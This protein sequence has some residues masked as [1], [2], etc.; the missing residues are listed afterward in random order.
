MRST[1]LL[2]VVLC[3]CSPPQGALDAGAACDAGA[4]APCVANENLACQQLVSAIV[5]LQQQLPCA[6]S[7]WS[8]FESGLLAQ[9]QEAIDSCSFEDSQILM[10][11]ESCL[12][13]LAACSGASCCAGAPLRA[14]SSCAFI[15]DGLSCAAVLPWNDTCA[16]LPDGGSSCEPGSST[17]L[18]ATFSALQKNV[19]NVSCDTSACHSPSG[20]ANAGFLDLSPANAYA[21][22]LGGSGAGGLIP[23]DAVDGGLRG[24]AT[25]AGEA[26]AADAGF[27]LVDP[28]N[29]GNSFLLLKLLPNVPAQYGL[30]MPAAG[31]LLTQQQLTAIGEWIDAGAPQD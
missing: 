9:C 22:L 21:S 25:L 7:D 10:S 23:A 1:A 31:T 16:Q 20:L 3:A 6:R 8:A 18:P 26:N 27:L 13:D 24:N 12:N 28:G 19:F 5:Q 29:P 17:P 30:Q 4:G 15:A 2:A 11:Y 14:L